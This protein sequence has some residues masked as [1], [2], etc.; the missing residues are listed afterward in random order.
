M[1]MATFVS[2]CQYCITGSGSIIVAGNR[3][4]LAD[5]PIPDR[6]VFCA[7]KFAEDA[8]PGSEELESYAYLSFVRTFYSIF[9]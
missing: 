9:K 8:Y 2:A 1:V 7:G 5:R 4:Y 6:W 3:R